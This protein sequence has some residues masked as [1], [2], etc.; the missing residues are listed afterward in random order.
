MKHPSVLLI[1]G[2]TFLL[3]GL[4]SSLRLHV[5]L[6]AFPCGVACVFC[7]YKGLKTTDVGIVSCPTFFIHDRNWSR[8]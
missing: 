5:P 3:V 4:L 2:I 8:S 6:L 7:C 1:V